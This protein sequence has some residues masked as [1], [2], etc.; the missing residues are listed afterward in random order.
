V[1]TATRAPAVPVPT[2][3]PRVVPARPL[4]QP[5]QPAQTPNI[6]VAGTP[7]P[8]HNLVGGESAST[9]GSA[10]TLQRAETGRIAA[11]P[12]ASPSIQ[13]TPHAAPATST[14][15]R[16][17]LDALARQVYEVLKRRLAAEQRRGDN[18]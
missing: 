5:V 10:A 16:P 13:R 1:P 15:D 18:R 8:S 4:N 17:D 12:P 11:A 6:P 7:L 9:G 14:P 3:T 2:P